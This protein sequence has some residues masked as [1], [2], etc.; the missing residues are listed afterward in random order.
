[1]VE[2]AHLVDFV[3]LVVL[4][5]LVCLVD[6]VGFVDL[7]LVYLVNLVIQVCQIRLDNFLYLVHSV[8]WLVDYKEQ[9][10]SN[11]VE[12][13]MVLDLVLDLVHSLA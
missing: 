1:M 13:F 12:L 8:C 3:Y 9:R 2:L 5:C 10:I 4:V 6:L 11:K 7:Y